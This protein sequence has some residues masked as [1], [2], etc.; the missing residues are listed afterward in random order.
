[1]NCAFAAVGGI[2]IGGIDIGIELLYQGSPIYN[3]NTKDTSKTIV[4]IVIV[5]SLRCA[6]LPLP[7][8]CS[9]MRCLG[10]LVIHNNGRLQHSFWRLDSG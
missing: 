6:S 7:C 9:L 5:S 3:L 2:V 8:R 1:M 10:F 4:T